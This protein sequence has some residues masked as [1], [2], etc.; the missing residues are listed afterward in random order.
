MPNRAVRIANQAPPS[1]AA[2]VQPIPA[3][4][5]L[6]LSREPRQGLELNP[7][8]SD[9]RLWGL[10]EMSD[11]QTPG[12]PSQEQLDV[13][14]VRS[15]LSQS[16]IDSQVLLWY[17]TREGKVLPEDKV[18]TIVDA[19]ILLSAGKRDTALESRFWSAFR[20]LA[21]AMQPV[22]VDSIRATYGYP[23]GGQVGHS[24]GL[25]NA[26]STKRWY[27]AG[28]LVVLTLIVFTQI[29]W[30]SGTQFRSDLE[31]HREELD[32]ISGALRDMSFKSIEIESKIRQKHAEGS[33]SFTNIKD[34]DLSM[35]K[36]VIS[37]NIV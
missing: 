2:K 16:V 23:F 36:A 18:Q 10:W 20:D 17:A 28:A 11:E 22:S 26:V 21:A 3:G 37:P 12:G 13:P 19:D 34:A 8:G 6:S 31:S 15:P 30:Y 14:A 1:Q 33:V 32:R 27:S 25:G 24:R 4:G 29:Y 7:A 35:G 9:C 5:E